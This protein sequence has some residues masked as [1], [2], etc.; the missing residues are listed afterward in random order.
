[1]SKF[2]IKQISILSAFFG[3]FLGVL[4]LIPIVRNLSI[5]ALMLF[6]AP[7]VIIYLK[8]I[9]VIKEV[10]IQTGMISGVVS[11]IVSIIAFMLVFTPIDLVLSLFIKE[12]YIY[13]ISSLIKNSGFFIYAML[14]F[15]MSVLNGLTNAFSGL[16]TAYVYE[17]LGKIKD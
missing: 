12:G 10:S 17:F 1:M 5:L 8:K 11:G 4:G 15:F 6:I 2:V 13:W 9:N 7:V 3:A 14:I 16:T